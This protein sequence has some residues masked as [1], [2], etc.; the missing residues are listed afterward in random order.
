MENR[1]YITGKIVPELLK[2]KIIYVK[3]CDDTEFVTI[4]NVEV[5]ELSDVGFAL[6]I[7]YSVVVTLT[8]YSERDVKHIF[9]LVVKI[10]PK[11]TEDIYLACQFDT[12]FQNEETAYTEIFPVLAKNLKSDT[13]YPKY[14]KIV[15]NGIETRSGS[16]F[17]RIFCH[18]E[19][20]V[21][22][23]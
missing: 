11:V 19:V 23:I 8:K 12:L 20:S 1:N 17:D 13:S 5:K 22:N 10:T 6:T 3:D 2:Q 16:N 4:E 7:P 18:L 9:D 14:L 15:D 21:I